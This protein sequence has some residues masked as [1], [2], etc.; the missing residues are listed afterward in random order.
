M[1]R[2]TGSSTTTD[3]LV[4]SEDVEER[5]PAKKNRFLGAGLADLD[6]DE[7]SGGVSKELENYLK[8][9]KLKVDEDPFAWWRNRRD[10]YPLMSKLA[11]KYLAVQ[12]TSTP[13]ER[14]ISRLGAVF[15]KRRQSLTGDMFSKIMFLSDLGL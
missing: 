14:V 11:R 3:A 8:E 13:A 10:E 12:G 1:E 9:R 7:A 6:D 5:E 2:N 15:T 4:Q